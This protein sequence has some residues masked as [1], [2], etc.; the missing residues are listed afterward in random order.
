MCRKFTEVLTVFSVTCLFS[1]Q[2]LKAQLNLPFWRLSG[3]SVGANTSFGT[4]NNAPLR[5][6]TNKVEK[7]RVTENGLVGIG[8]ITP[9][10]KLHVVG[11]GLFTSG[12]SVS[13]GGISVLNSNG[14]AVSALGH[15]GISSIGTNIAIE[16][17]TDGL[18]NI[19]VLAR[20]LTNGPAITAQSN[21]GVGIF[22][23]GSVGVNATGFNTGAILN[24][25]SF[26]LQVN[27]SGSSST[28]VYSLGNFSGVTGVANGTDPNARGVSGFSDKTYGVVGFSNSG[29][30]VYGYTNG[31]DDFN[32]VVSAVYG[33]C[34]GYGV[35]VRA[36]SRNGAGVFA[37]S[38][39]TYAGY[40]SGNVYSTGMYLGSDRKLKKNIAEVTSALDIINKLQPKTYEFREDGN[41]KLMNLPKGKH[42]GLLAHE[43][44]QVLPGLVKETS[45][46]TAHAQ[47]MEKIEAPSI[48]PLEN[49]KAQMVK[50]KILQTKNLKL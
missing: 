16:A 49:S 22:A 18:N 11:Q 12:L 8:T 1:L 40:F 35:G 4:T 26:G 27:A 37:Y 41:Y 6:I 24:G 46:N 17:I 14:I 7:I 25:V 48:Q 45:F 36:F 15:K 20:N 31:L 2:S 43:L 28:G 30:G 3:N 32:N 10:Q 47:P 50:P 33:E 39:G 19:G 34:Q 21:S 42:F 44:E 9:L 13:N 38:T 29:N 5:I 23:N